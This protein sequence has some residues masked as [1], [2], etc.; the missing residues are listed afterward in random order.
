MIFSAWY[1]SL[2]STALFQNIP[3]NSLPFINPKFNSKLI[4]F[5]I[6][7]IR[8]VGRG[9]FRNSHTKSV[10]STIG[11]A[12]ENFLNCQDVVGSMERL[13]TSF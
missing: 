9:L 11:G 7:N 6:S 2:K 12:G 13:L 8:R 4:K 10:F 1:F 5:F 3:S